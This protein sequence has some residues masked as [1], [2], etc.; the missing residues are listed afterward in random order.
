MAHNFEVTIF[1]KN[2]RSKGLGGIWSNV[3]KTSG[4]QINSVMYRYAFALCHDELISNS[5]DSFHPA[6][7]WKRSLPQAEEITAGSSPFNLELRFWRLTEARNPQNLEELQ[8]R[9]SHQF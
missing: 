9:I 2:S 4:L 5:F 3:N 8:P 1:E 6:V 7:F